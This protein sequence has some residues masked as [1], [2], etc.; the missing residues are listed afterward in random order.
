MLTLLAGLLTVSCLGGK[1]PEPEAIAVTVT[2]EAP[3]S[4]AEPTPTWQQWLGDKVAKGKCGNPNNI[5]MYRNVRK[6][7]PYSADFFCQA[8]TP[9]PNVVATQVAATVT[10]IPTPT[11]QPRVTPRPTLAP[12]STPTPAW[13]Q[14]ATPYPTPTFNE[15]LGREISTLKCDYPRDE[16][17]W[18]VAR[19]T[20]PY[21]ANFSC[22]SP[23]PRP[24][25]TTRPTASPRPTAT[26][27][28]RPTATP[29]QPEIPTTEQII[30]WDPST[31]AAKREC[32]QVNGEFQISNIRREGTRWAWNYN[33]AQGYMTQAPQP[34]E[35]TDI[36]KEL[37]RC[38]TSL[39]TI[40]EAVG[41]GGIPYSSITRC[42]TPALLEA[43]SE[44]FSFDSIL[45]DDGGT[46]PQLRAEFDYSAVVPAGNERRI[47]AQAEEYGY[48][49]YKF[50]SVKDTYSKE[51]LKLTFRIYGNDQRLRSVV[52]AGESGSFVVHEG[53]TMTLEFDNS[54]SLIT[55]KRVWWSWH[56]SKSP[57]YK[58]R[59]K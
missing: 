15:W 41:S 17:V 36:V 49:N 58:Y 5:L 29:R 20:W 7:P 42:M 3:A 38:G 46:N 14:T 57:D 40:I 24:R 12:V 44:M 32:D 51:L 4:V 59:Y 54:S 35:N 10:T 45:T 31:A 19:R 37:I 16:L 8:P 43:L 28:P 22:V 6:E 9:V 2:Q 25:A 27:M 30:A 47:S 34:Q 21:K 11:R 26:L 50:V 56:W 48:L 55:G 23:T 13:Q 18:E 33:C 53:E 39:E 52:T 1:A